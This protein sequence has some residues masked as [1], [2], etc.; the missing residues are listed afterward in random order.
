MKE[1]VTSLPLCSFHLRCQNNVLFLSLECFTHPCSW[2][3]HT[4]RHTNYCCAGPDVAPSSERK[5]RKLFV[6]QLVLL[7]CEKKTQDF[8]FPVFTLYKLSLMCILIQSC[9]TKIEK[10]SQ[11]GKKDS[12]DERYYLPPKNLLSTTITRS[13][14]A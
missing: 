4:R 5:T 9:K 6:L 12:T 13:F 2:L 10:A 7:G 8:M 14:F 3:T 1:H 11:D